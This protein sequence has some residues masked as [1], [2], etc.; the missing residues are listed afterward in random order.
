M[1]D[2]EFIAQARAFPSRGRAR[3]NTD[4]LALIPVNEEDS[5]EVYRTGQEKTI[6]VTVFADAHVDKGS[7]RLSKEDLEQLDARE[8]DRLSVRKKPDITESIK[9]S[10]DEFARNVNAGLDS[11]GSNIGAAIDPGVK[12]ID[13]ALM[14]GAAKVTGAVG[15]ITLPEQVTNLI[16]GAK[17]TLSPGDAAELARILKA[18]EGAVRS[19][20]VAAGTP[21]RML[22]GIKLPTGVVVAAIRRGDDVLMHGPSLA[23]LAGDTVFLVG[24]EPGL[25]EAAQI[26]G[27]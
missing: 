11:V 14:G 18:N 24:K 27:S 25:S 21:V 12:K 20:T 9:K 2:M 23:V 7:I 22:A 5:L 10:T 3:L 19:V 4:D 16:E 15:S 8:G 13:S 6:S 1:A 26:I 17:K